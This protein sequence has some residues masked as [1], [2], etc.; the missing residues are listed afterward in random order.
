MATIALLQMTSSSDIQRNLD[1]VSAAFRQLAEQAA[2]VDMVL[3]PENWASYGNRDITRES[4]Q[5]REQQAAI[6]AHVSALA[7]QYRTWIIAGTIP[8]KYQSEQQP[9]ACCPVFDDRGQLVAEYRKIHLF[10][11]MIADGHRLYRE[12]ATYR[13]GNTLTV[14]N[15]PIGRVG[16]SVCY[17]LRFAEMYQ[18]L[19]VMGAEVMVAPA[20]F[21]RPTG[22]AHWE[23]LN[24]ARAVENA[25]YMLSPAQVGSHD[26]SRQTWG[27]SMVIEPWGRVQGC[28]E[29]ETGWLM[30]DINRARVRAMRQTMPNQEHR[31][32]TVQRW[33]LK[34]Q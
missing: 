24:R 15:T 19:R 26:D 2:P 8:F 14:V 7:R 9:W 11:A 17:D 5:S 16:L 6:M 27:H 22:E 13:H 23:L 21:T 30:G 28:L 3:L 29:N 12:S 34:T 31:I 20:A 25:C 1:F 4:R 32:Q 10:D 33:A 18:R